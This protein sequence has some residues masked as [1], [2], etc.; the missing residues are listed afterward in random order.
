MQQMHC[1][2]AGPGA[3]V[4]HGNVETLVMRNLCALILPAILSINSFDR[5]CEETS[6]MMSCMLC[7]RTQVS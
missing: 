4:C 7:D 3:D 2:I 6:I 1:G 5:V